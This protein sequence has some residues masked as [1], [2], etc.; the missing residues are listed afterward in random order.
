MMSDS[1][2]LKRRQK[3]KNAQKKK[4][5]LKCESVK[6]QNCENLKT[7]N[8]ITGSHPYPQ[9]TTPESSLPHMNGPGKVVSTKV[10]HILKIYLTFSLFL[11]IFNNTISS[12]MSPRIKG[13]SYRRS[14]PGR[15][16]CRPGRDLQIHFTSLILEFA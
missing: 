16:P 3:Y 12:N 6:M 9:E 14:L 10:I 5:L 7:Q 13:E 1:L 4:Q 8:L 2:I 11:F 15:S